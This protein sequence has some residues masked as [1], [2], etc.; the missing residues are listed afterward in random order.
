M[1]DVLHPGKVGV[2]R[3]WHAV[4]PALIHH[5]QITTPVADVEGWVGENKVGLEV[6]EAVI[7][8]GVAVR[9]L[10]VDATDGEVH[11]R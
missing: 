9:D 7:V 4:L 1:D 2:A 11:T 3:R 10:A 6:R 5:Q 8:E